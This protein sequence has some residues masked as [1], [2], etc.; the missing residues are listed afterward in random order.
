MRFDP[1]GASIPRVLSFWGGV[2]HFFSLLFGAVWLHNR[3]QVV[4]L[5]PD[6]LGIILLYS[7]A[8]R[9]DIYLTCICT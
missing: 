5:G 1:Q 6:I 4:P 7:S 8:V 3:V 2:Y 9:R